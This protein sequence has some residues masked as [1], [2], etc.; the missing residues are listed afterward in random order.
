M[1]T[2]TSKQ[3]FLYAQRTDGLYILNVQHSAKHGILCNTT[4]YLTQPS[5][6]RVMNELEIITATIFDILVLTHW[7]RLPT[8]LHLRK[9]ALTLFVMRPCENNVAYC[10]LKH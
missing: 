6:S 3:I 4:Q 8:F 2:A 7:I 5:M 1:Y 10:F 9:I